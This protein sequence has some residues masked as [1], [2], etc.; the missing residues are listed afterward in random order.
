MKKYIACYDI[1][2]NSKRNKVLKRLKNLGF[3]SQ[4]SFFEIEV[5]NG[6]S[7]SESVKGI[8]E[9]TDR[10]AVI[11]LSNK[12]KIRRIGSIIEGMEWVI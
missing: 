3:H 11:K 6:K 8:I 2:S 9:N 5:K 12:G 7:I 10:F 1:S 4:L